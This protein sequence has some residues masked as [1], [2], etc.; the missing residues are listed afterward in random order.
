MFDAFTS[1]NLL[2][3]IISV[4]LAFIPVVIWFGFLFKG[5]KTSRVPHIV[6]FYLGC[7]TVIPILLLDNL[8]TVFPVLDVYKHIDLHI[9]DVH[10]AAF[11]ALV[12]VGISE[13]M[14]K[15]MVVRFIDFSKIKIQ[16]VN[17]SIRYAILAGLGFSF[18][19]NLFY[20]VI[21]WT[22]SGLAD[23]IFPMIFRSMFTVTA[24]IVF[25]GIF[26]Y[27]YGISKFAKPLIE[28]QQLSG[29]SVQ[30][31]KFM[32]AVMGKYSPA[33]YGQYLLLKGMFIAMILHALFDFFLEFE[34]FLPVMIIV[35]GGFGYLIYLLSKKIL[36]L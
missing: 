10:F 17:D 31:M 16:T 9:T 4:I 7:M 33:G 1:E 30:G 26:G 2:Q 23:L 11:A 15:S 12:F 21:I 20:F 27:Y 28:A 8:W 19:E 32:K 13:E 36:N 29:E 35:L 6:A 5:R 14:A 34:L 25:S 3:I 22:G 24:H 18:I